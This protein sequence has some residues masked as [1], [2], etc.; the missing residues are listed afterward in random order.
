MDHRKF[1]ISRIVFA[2]LL[3]LASLSSRAETAGS[4]IETIVVSGS[5]L[6]RSVAESTQSV[7]MLTR[8]DIEGRQIP[9][10]TEFLRQVAGI[11]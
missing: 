10:V 11:T 9:N 6:E 5:R 1:L 3:C 8:E 4:G 2:S 7:E